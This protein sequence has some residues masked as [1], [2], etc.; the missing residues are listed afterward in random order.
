MIPAPPLIAQVRIVFYR[1]DIVRLWLA[2][3]G[4]FTDPTHGKIAIGSDFA[5]P[6]VTVTEQPA[7]FD[8]A[9]DALHL[10]AHKAALTFSLYSTDG[11]LLFAETQPL[12]WNTSSTWQTLERAAAEQFYGCG[13]QNGAFSHRGNM[14]LIEQGGGWDAGGRW[15]ALD[16]TSSAATCVSPRTLLA[17]LTR[18]G[19]T[20]PRST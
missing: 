3:N 1:S 2:P 12:T 11:T 15:V 7:W 18:A 14:V 13:M 8:I 19:P 10:R 5:F 20:P 17:A 16:A 9:S 4:A 6:R